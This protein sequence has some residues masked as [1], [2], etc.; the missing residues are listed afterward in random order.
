MVNSWYSSTNF[1][2]SFNQPGKENSE[3]NKHKSAL[4]STEM[5]LFINRAVLFQSLCQSVYT[6][7]EIDLT[8]TVKTKVTQVTLALLSIILKYRRT[9]FSP[10]LKSK[11][12]LTVYLNFF[13]NS[14]VIKI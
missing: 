13:F 1:K 11:F 10:A 2:E 12:S 4:T 8:I 9:E 6:T 3:M 7:Y 14:N 5:R